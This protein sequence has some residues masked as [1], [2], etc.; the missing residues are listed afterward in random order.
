MVAV[1]IIESDSGGDELRLSML[2][3]TIVNDEKEGDLM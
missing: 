3:L 1:I 2:L